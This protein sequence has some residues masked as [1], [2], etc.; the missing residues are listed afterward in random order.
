M[1]YFIKTTSNQTFVSDG[2][3]NYPVSTEEAS[4]YAAN[5]DIEQLFNEKSFEQYQSI[6]SHIAYEQTNRG[7][8][9]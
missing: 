1:T 4:D 8:R 2:T 6:A 9:L 7:F 5:N 3:V